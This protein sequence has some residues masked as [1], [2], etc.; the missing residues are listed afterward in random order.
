MKLT[1]EL[2]D[3]D[4]KWLDVIWEDEAELEVKSTPDEVVLQAN[5]E[6]LISLAEQ[7]LYLAHH[8][9]PRGSHIHLDAGMPGVSGPGLVLEKK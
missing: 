3:Y 5:R 7:L 1:L 8:E 4:G 9:L 2:P 6:G